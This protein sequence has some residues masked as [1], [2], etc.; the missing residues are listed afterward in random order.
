MVGV[1]EGKRVVVGSEVNVGA[2]KGVMVT[3]RVGVA[4]LNKPIFKIPV[5]EVIKN[6]AMAR[7]QIIPI[8]RIKKIA[9]GK[10]RGV[11]SVAAGGDGD[12]EIGT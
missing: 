1:A 11:A 9:N 4:A 10:E 6:A 7:T 3:V 12:G 2:M 8:P 5:C